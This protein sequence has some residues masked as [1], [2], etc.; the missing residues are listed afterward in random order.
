MYA[1]FKAIPQFKAEKV[2]Q[3]L[4]NLFEE[5]LDVQ[6]E[7]FE[8][9]EKFQAKLLCKSEFQVQEIQAPQSK[10]ARK[11]EDGDFGETCSM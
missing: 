2:F 8:F 3:D 1:A 11:M 6:S 9:E 5:Q 4:T 7:V 10:R